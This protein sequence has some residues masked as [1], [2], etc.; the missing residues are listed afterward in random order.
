MQLKSE[1]LG[2]V[3]EKI[4]KTMNTNSKIVSVNQLKIDSGRMT[5]LSLLYVY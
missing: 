3:L 2:Q 5:H 4:F 1:V